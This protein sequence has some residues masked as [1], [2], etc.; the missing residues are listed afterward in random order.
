MWRRL[1]VVGLALAL[2]LL[3]PISQAAKPAGDP[4]EAGEIDAPTQQ[5]WSSSWVPIIPGNT[6]TLAHGLGGDPLD[7]S[8]QLWFRDTGDGYG[9][10]TRAYG[11]LE[12]GGLRYGALWRQLTNANVEVFRFGA[13]A[14]ADEVRMWI[15]FPED[16][17]EWCSTGWT[18]IA[19]GGS[20]VFTH[21]LGGDPE[22]YVVGLWFRGPAG[23]GINQQFFGGMEDIGNDYGA[24]WR[25]LTAS[26]ITVYRAADDP[27]ASE[28]RVCITVADPPD[29][30]SGWV[31]INA[32]ETAP[33]THNLGGRV[34]RYVVRIEFK[35]ADPSGL[36]IHLQ[37]VGGNAVEAN[38]VGAAWQN[39]T[40]SSIQVYRYPNDVTADQV[41]VRIWERATTS[42][43]LPLVLYNY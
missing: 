6:V 32:G 35:D 2:A 30:D 22:D 18:A 1:L 14:Y 31:D 34:D 42:V 4:Q 9:I 28:V 41:R 23:V 13:D 17:P 33:L 36:G 25:S 29:Y 24:W 39:L 11:G 12:S 43:Y 16:P 37:N 3:A 21:N 10:N 20:Q 8:V 27:V 19:A 5:G 15:W 26:D 7:Y 40:D 38:W